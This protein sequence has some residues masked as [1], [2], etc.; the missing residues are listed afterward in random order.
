MTVALPSRNL[1]TQVLSVITLSVGLL[2]GLASTTLAQAV[3]LPSPRL[4]TTT[5]MGGQVGTTVEVTISGQDVEDV[6]L[7]TFSHPGITAEAKVDDQGEPIANQYIV[8]IAEDCPVGIHEARVMTRLGLSTSRVFNVGSLPEVQQ[9]S[10]NTSLETAMPLPI[11]TVCNAKM[12]AQAVDHYT[13]E[14]AAGQRLVVDCAAKG[15]D[16]KLNAVLI[17]ADAQGN[18]LQVERRGGAVDFTVPEAGTYVVKVHDLTF[19]GG[20][21]YF[22]RLVIQSAEADELVQRLPSTQAVS[23]FSWPPT[24]LT[25]EQLIAEAELNNQHGEAQA[26]TLPCDISGSFYPAADVDTFEFTA[27]KGDVWWVEVASERLGRETDPSIVVQHVSRDGETEKLTDV[28]ELT[29]IASPVKVSSN[30]YSYDGPPYNA[31]STD[32][33]GKLEI[34]EDGLHRLQLH[35]LFGGTR[36]DPD[37]VYRLIIRKAAPDFALV[38]WALHMNLR[39]GDRNALSKPIALR[40]G[41]TMPL[42]VVVVRRDGFVG[43]IEMEMSDLPEGVT[44]TGLTIP[45]GQ[46]KGIMLV[47]AN[48][49]APRG[50]SRASF[51]GRATINGEEVTRP[52]RLASMAWPI[53]DAW[54]LIPDPRL[55]ADVPVSVCGIEQAPLTIAAAEDKVWEVTSGEKL[56]IPLALTRRCDF[57]GANISLNTYG[58]GF[59]GASAFEVPLDEETSEIVYDLATLKTAP[60]EYKVALYGSA[61]AKYRDQ[62]ESIAI[63]EVSLMQVQ[64]EAKRLAEE[65]ATLTEEAQAATEEAKADAEAAAAEVAEKLK[66]AEDAVATAQKQLEAATNRAQPKDIVDI[67]VSTPF[68]I[69]VNPAEES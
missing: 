44:A 33:L 69:R 46:S 3:C 43:Q 49:D 48:E 23:S 67:I 40:G 25:D 35:D 21:E 18:D 1:A 34:K 5:P 10:P 53:P 30:G 62:V 61:V 17:V 14:A 39:N 31:G 11:D 26:I 42:E 60:G 36:S 41:A 12:A 68:T 55:L 52:C 4:L 7:L 56:T 45:S 65:V 58:S 19:S 32:I 16:S 51:V 24:G 29:D 64:E 6:D 27:T 15:I 37:N 9:V 57:S 63:A 2:F 20:A 59:D 66:A 50:L 38:G 8:T 22:Y 28:V 54:S 13:F 47:S